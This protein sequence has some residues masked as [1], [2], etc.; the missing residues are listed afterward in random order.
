MTLDSPLH[1][2]DSYT[3]IWFPVFS[4]HTVNCQTEVFTGTPNEHFKFTISNTELL[5]LPAEDLVTEQQK[6]TKS[7]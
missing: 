5:I 1:A 2:A 7:P 4:T 3:Y 6:T